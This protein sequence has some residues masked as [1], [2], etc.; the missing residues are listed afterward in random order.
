MVIASLIRRSHE[1][2]HCYDC[3]L[4]KTDTLLKYPLLALPHF[5]S[6]QKIPSAPTVVY[7]HS[8]SPV[9]PNTI[10]NNGFESENRK[11]KF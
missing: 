2:M 3:F 7:I 8:G 6:R 5:L 11:S 10:G 9:E 4:C 1:L